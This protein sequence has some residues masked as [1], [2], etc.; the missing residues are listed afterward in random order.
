MEGRVAAGPTTNGARAGAALPGVLLVMLWLTGVT[1]W[2]VAHTA[3]SAGIQ[4]E[5]HVVLTLGAAADAMGAMAARV[6][7]SQPDWH[8]VGGAAGPGPCPGAAAPGVD[9]AVLAT[10]AARLQA[11][12]DAISRW[13]S[14][15][16]PVWRPWLACGADD[17]LG[18]WRGAGP[19]PWVVALVA[20]DPDGLTLAGQPAQIAVAAVAGTADGAR[21]RRL[22]AVRRAALDMPPRIVAWRQG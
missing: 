13:P 15:Q 16:R 8:V 5:E 3:W 2:L 14:A 22:L 18:G 19:A 12:T 20:D 17:L 7:A 21:V 11:A 6:L 9:P 4:R 10:E 1:G